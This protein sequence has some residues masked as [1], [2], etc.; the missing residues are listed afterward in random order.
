M[1]MVILLACQCNNVLKYNMLFRNMSVKN[2]E[3][4]WW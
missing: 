3:L 4:R 1:V 2:V